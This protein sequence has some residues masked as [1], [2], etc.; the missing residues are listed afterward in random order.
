[1]GLRT[2]M[3][4]DR[5]RAR[6]GAARARAARFCSF[7]SIIANIMSNMNMWIRS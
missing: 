5:R 2:L 7:I 3:T 1:V 6:Q 4:P